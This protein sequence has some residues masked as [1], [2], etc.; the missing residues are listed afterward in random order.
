MS[1]AGNSKVL[2]PGLS[3]AQL[4]KEK[5]DARSALTLEEFQ[6]IIQSNEMPKEGREGT[7]ACGGHAFPPQAIAQQTYLI[8]IY[9]SLVLDHL[10]FHVASSIHYFHS[11]KRF[12]LFMNHHKNQTP[13]S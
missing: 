10:D 7:R 6:D 2:D 3:A 5:A 1:A 11:A 4:S 9:L 12:I 13:H 8:R